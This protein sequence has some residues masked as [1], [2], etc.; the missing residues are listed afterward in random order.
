MCYLKDRKKGHEEGY[1]GIDEQGL[2]STREVSDQTKQDRTGDGGRKREEI[3]I[4]GEGPHLIDSRQFQDHGQ[5]ID[6]DGS[7]EH[8][9]YEQQDPNNPEVTD[10]QQRDEYKEQTEKTQNDRPASAYTICNETGRHSKNNKG[11]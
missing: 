5:R 1:G 2:K 9:T 6:I 4:T 8:P 3:I 10:K 11:Y 7:P